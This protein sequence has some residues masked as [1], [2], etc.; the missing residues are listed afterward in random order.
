MALQGTIKDFG[1]ADILQMIGIQQK[2]GILTLRNGDDSVSIK[3]LT[4]KV[5]GADTARRGLEDLLGSVLVSTGRIT[6]MQLREALRLQQKTLQRL[7]HVLVRS[8]LISEDDL[9]D[10]LRVQSLQI[11]FRLFRWREGSY[12]FRTLD[13]VEYDDKHFMPISAET[14]LMEGARMVDEWPIIERRIKSDDM[15]LRRTE[16][17][18]DL[19]LSVG[20]IVDTDIEFDFGFGG[21]TQAAVAVQEKTE[22]LTLSVEEREV[23]NLVDGSR[24]AEEINERTAL[25]EFDTYRILAD[26]MTRNLVEE[27][28]RQPVVKRPAE[29]SRLV[30][31][32][33]RFVLNTII[34]LAVVMALATLSS[35]PLAP[36]RL[37]SGEE[38][39][40]QLRLYTSQVRME[41]ID[42]AIQIFYLDAG[43]FPRSLDRLATYGYLDP[44][45]LIDPWGRPYAYGISPGGYQLVGLDGDGEARGELSI[46]HKFSTTQRV[47][48]AEAALPAQ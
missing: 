3:F 29:K 30:D 48:E 5:V 19:D 7:G 47:M 44:A 17:A 1:L 36:W 2:S 25:G 8:G 23:M 43:S 15:I 31:L 9:V 28:K 4:G 45:E 6:E 24:T 46:S 26:L 22:K 39:V 20:S 33:V 38:S 14:I 13:N 37:Q 27:V 41:Q 18:K 12:S 32:V 16:A 40:S 21:D 10:A 35:N 42:K 11:I 34:V